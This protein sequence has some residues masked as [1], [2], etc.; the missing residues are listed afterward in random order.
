MPGMRDRFHHA[1]NWALPPLLFETRKGC[2]IV[3]D[4][5]ALAYRLR[6]LCSPFSPSFH[7]SPWFRVSLFAAFLFYRLVCVERNVLSPSSSRGLSGS[8]FGS[9]LFFR[10]FFACCRFATGCKHLHL[11]TRAEQAAAFSAAYQKLPVHTTTLRCL[12]NFKGVFIPGVS[13]KKIV[14]IIKGRAFHL[15]KDGPMQVTVGMKQFMH[16]EAYTGLTGDGR[17]VGEPH[18]LFVGSPPQPADA[19]PFHFK[20]LEE[21]LIKKIQQRYDCVHASLDTLYPDGETLV[22]LSL[23]WPLADFRFVERRMSFFSV[24]HLASVCV[25]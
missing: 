17:F 7:G 19:P 12:G 23:S 21:A 20:D 1:L 13:V 24:T 4:I 8:L 14:G 25:L 18:E 10:P 3:V 16:H 5:R 6:S 15:L 11:F 2:N 22:L 9:P